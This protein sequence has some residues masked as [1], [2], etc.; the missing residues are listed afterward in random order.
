VSGRGIQALRDANLVVETGVLQDHA[1]ALNAP[2]FKFRERGL[3]HVLLK[4]ALSIDGR[5]VGPDARERW[6][7]SEASREI[8]HAMRGDCDCVMVGIGTVL[9]DDP[10]LSDRRRGAR[11]RQPVRLAVDRRLRIPGSSTLARSATEL[12]TVV[13][14][15]TEASPERAG[16]LES[17]GVRIWRCP[18]DEWGLDL[19][20]VLARAALEGMLSVLS[21]GGP[22]IAAS[23]LRAGLVD[24]V[25]IFVAPTL[26]GSEGLPAF[27]ALGDTRWR[28]GWLFRDPTW[29]VVG[30]DVLFEAA[31]DRAGGAA[32]E[33]PRAAPAVA[34]GDGKGVE[35]CSQGSLRR[36]DGSTG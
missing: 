9:A 25:A 26:L 36:R 6:M 31:I 5:V 35:R 10:E 24:R 7:T 29:R 14:C 2:Y 3:P 8:V 16:E 32:R 12:R 18:G 23:L 34:E 27:G 22:R 28:D 30:R 4:M 17:Q 15:G 33:G 11:P 20:A 1:L 13:A 19:S 21:E